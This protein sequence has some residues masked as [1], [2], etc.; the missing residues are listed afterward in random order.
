MLLRIMYQNIRKTLMKGIIKCLSIYKTFKEVLDKLKPKDFQAASFS[1]YKF[2]TLYTTLPHNLI[3]EKLTHLINSRRYS[4]F[5]LNEICVCFTSEEHR[6][7]NLFYGHVEIF[8]F[9][10]IYFLE[11]ALNFMEKL[12]V[13]RCGLIVLP[14][15]RIR[16]YFAMREAFI[17]SHFS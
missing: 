15:L 3:L 14:L 2:S 13:F 10:R 9:W 17:S 7:Y 4:I 11:L 6:N 1:I 8:T 12:W 5:G 16:F